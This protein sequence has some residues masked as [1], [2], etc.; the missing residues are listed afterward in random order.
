MMP[1]INNRDGTL[2]IFRPSDPVHLVW[3]T[4]RIASR[5]LWWLLHGQEEGQSMLCFLWGDLRLQM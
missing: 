2:I 5:Q 4:D 1:I 3:I